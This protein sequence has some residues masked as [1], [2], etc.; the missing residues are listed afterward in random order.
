MSILINMSL[1]DKIDM[2]FDESKIK[3]II[4]N[5]KEDLTNKLNDPLRIEIDLNLK[6][7]DSKL[8]FKKKYITKILLRNYGNISKTS[9]ILK[10]D[11]RSLHRLIENLSIDVN[12]MREQMLKPNYVRINEVKNKITEIVEQYKHKIPIKEY[13]KI[14]S[15][16]ENISNSIVIFID[17]NLISLNEAIKLFEKRYFLYLINNKQNKSKETFKTISKKIGLSYE[18]LIRKLKEYG[19]KH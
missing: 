7:K 1:I 14:Y 15:K 13:V 17:E 10:I 12:S 5:L 19:I 3:N 8:I 11:R 4:I 16:I 2:L 6:Y 18:T 9:E